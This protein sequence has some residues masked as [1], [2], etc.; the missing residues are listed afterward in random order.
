MARI[1]AMAA[2]AL[3][4]GG[5]ISIYDEWPYRPA[6]RRY[7]SWSLFDADVRMEL[8]EGWMKANGVENGIVATRDG[9]NLQ[10]LRF[11]RLRLGKPLPHT[12]KALAEGMRPDELAE[13]LIDDIR[14]DGTALGL[15]ILETR[16]ATVAGQPGFRAAILFKDPDG[17]RFKAATAGVILEGY[18]WQ[19][20]FVAAARHYYDRDLPLF[21]RAL[22]SLQ[23]D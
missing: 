9:F 2:A 14:S 11:R 6:G 19:L 4:L 21:E 7:S 20:T 17:L 8:P 3:L 18:A 23:I 1:A 13:V 12:K 5:C 16:P 10:T 15:Q 22:A